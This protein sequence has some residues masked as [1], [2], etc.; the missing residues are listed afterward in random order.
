MPS[1]I[2][3]WGVVI[4]VAAVVLLFGPKK[5]PSLGRS[6][7]RGFRDLKGSYEREKAELEQAIGRD[8]RPTKRASER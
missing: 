5:V 8:P 3:V 6:L 7:A 1:W 2:G 4:I